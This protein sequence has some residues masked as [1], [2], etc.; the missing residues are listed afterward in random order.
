MLKSIT[1]CAFLIQGLAIAAVLLGAD[2]F[3]INL[4][5]MAS[6]FFFVILT[7]KSK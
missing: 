2:P 4:A 5:L 1:Q 7:G 3:G 6:F